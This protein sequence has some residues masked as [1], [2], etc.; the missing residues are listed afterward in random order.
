LDLLV[1][2]FRGPYV[3]TWI[4]ALAILGELNLLATTSQAVSSFI[5]RRQKF[6][7]A[8]VAL[9]PRLSDVNLLK[10]WATDLLKIMGK[11]GSHLGEDRSAIYKYIAPLCPQNSALYRQLGKAQSLTLSVKGLADIEWTTV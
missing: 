7:S 3:L 5:S 2:F 8:D 6:D 9:Q 11:F 1:K 4:Y 10:S